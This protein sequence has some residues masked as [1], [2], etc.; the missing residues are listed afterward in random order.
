MWKVILSLKT[1]LAVGSRNFLALEIV[2]G[3]YVANLFALVRDIFQEL[4]P[5]L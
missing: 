4:V 2:R 5:V 1:I 3:E